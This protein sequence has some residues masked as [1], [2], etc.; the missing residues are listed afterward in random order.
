MT[1]TLDDIRARAARLELRVRRRNQRE[2][3][4]GAIGAIWLSIQIWLSHGRFLTTGVLLIGALIFVMWQLHL[5]GAR[6][7]P[8]DAGLRPLLEFHRRELE[9]QRD[10]LRSVW[11]WYFLPFVPGLA[12]AVIESALQRGFTPMVASIAAFFVLVLVGG[13]ALN[14]WAA[15]KLDRKIR[16][17]QALQTD[18]E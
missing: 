10:A 2:Y 17:L 6:P 9:R 8:D 4:A 11:S 13:W 3:I 7:I 14:Q 16:D 12:A 1:I 18:H 5:R 15:S